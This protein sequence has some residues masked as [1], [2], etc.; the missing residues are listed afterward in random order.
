MKKQLSFPI[1]EK[2]K[3][4]AKQNAIIER[5]LFADY[6]VAVSPSFSHK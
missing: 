3:C 2:V 5:K 1:N 6:S 4:K